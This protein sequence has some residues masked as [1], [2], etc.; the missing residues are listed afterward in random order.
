MSNSHPEGGHPMERRQT[1]KF[2]DFNLCLR[3]LFKEKKNSLVWILLKSRSFD[4]KTNI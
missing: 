3:T 1:Q 2:I 4:Q